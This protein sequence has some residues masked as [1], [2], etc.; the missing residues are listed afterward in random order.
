M[1]F[2]LKFGVGGSEMEK[3]IKEMERTEE[4]LVVFTADA[5]DYHSIVVALKGCCA[6]FCCLDSPE[7]YDVSF[8][9]L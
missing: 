4:K 6:M 9:V 3:K 7:G 8:M 5:M 1:G 2:G